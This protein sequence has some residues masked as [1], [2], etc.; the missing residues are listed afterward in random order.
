MVR[1]IVR[2][3]A[4]GRKKGKRCVLG[5]RARGLRKAKRCRRFVR[6]GKS[7]FTHAGRQ[8]ANAFRFTGFLG[9]RPLRPGAHRLVGVPTDSAGNRGGRFGAPFVIARR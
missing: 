6:V 3:R 2:R 4:I 8:G 5:K 9:G 1:F 7:A